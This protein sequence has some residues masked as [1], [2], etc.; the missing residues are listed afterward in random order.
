MSKVLVKFDK[1]NNILNKED[2]VYS[3]YSKSRLNKHGYKTSRRYVVDSV[4]SKYLLG[5]YGNK[6][7]KDVLSKEWWKKRK[8]QIL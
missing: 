3:V 4:I 5:L 2:I 7:K 1:E 8:E 6:G